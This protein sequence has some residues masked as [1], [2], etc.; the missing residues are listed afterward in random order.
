MRLFRPGLIAGLLFPDA[1]FRISTSK[2]LLCLTF[3]DGPDPDSTPDLLDILSKNNIKAI[4]FCKGSAAE[5]FPDLIAQI[6]MRG[7][8]VG[9]HGYDHPNGWVTSLRSYITDVMKAE[10]Y[11]SSLLFRPPFG[12]LRI[13]QYMKLKKRYKI[14][15]WDI[16]PYDFDY[17]ISSKRSLCILKRK[18]RPGSIIVL[19]DNSKSNLHGFF[20]EFISFAR[21][22][23]Y[24]F[25]NS[26]N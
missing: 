12:R 15:F 14:V 13:S 10:P 6:R 3:D 4:F 7:H 2:K 1:I 26:I 24:S 25:I 19:H 8:Q 9:N 16:M 22:R 17:M 20:E 23:G 18:I 21:E 11:T 5:K